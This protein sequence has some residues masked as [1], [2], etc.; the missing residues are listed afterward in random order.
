M[1][2]SD[3]LGCWRKQCNKSRISM[4]VCA[5]G[6]SKHLVPAQLLLPH[7]AAPAQAACTCVP[8]HTQC[9]SA[10]TYPDPQVWLQLCPSNVSGAHTV[11]SSC[12]QCQQPLHCHFPSGCTS[13]LPKARSGKYKAEKKFWAQI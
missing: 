2:L 13:G 6:L 5:A 4:C 3:Q 7:S 9:V 11:L 1:L 8:I 10:G 12:W